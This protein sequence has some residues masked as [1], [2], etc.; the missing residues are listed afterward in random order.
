M[1]ELADN[2]R[3][4][5]YGWAILFAI[6]V[7]TSLPPLIGY[8]TAQTLIGF[9]YGITP[10]F[11][12]SAGSCLVGGVFS[13]LVVRRLVRFFAPFIQRDQTFQALSNAV[14]VKG[15]PLII[16][17]RLCPFP[18]PYSNAFFASVESVTLS[19]FFLA[20]LT[21]TPKLLLHVFIGHR[22]YLFA[23]PDAR[24]KMDPLSRW[25]N[26][27]F[28]VVGSALGFGTSWYLYRVTMRF[29]EEAERERSLAA[30]GRDGRGDGDVDL[31]LESGL[32]GQ[33]DEL[34][35]GQDDDDAEEHAVEEERRSTRHRPLAKTKEEK[36]VDVHDEE[37]DEDEGWSR[38][39][40]ADFSDFEERTPTRGPAEGA[41]VDIDETV[42]PA[43]GAAAGTGGAR[44][45]SEAWGFDDDLADDDVTPAPNA[46]P[47]KKR[48][49]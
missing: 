13:F 4:L 36:L 26:L 17:L 37:E 7:V 9:S 31:D 45:D 32:L 24:H 18:Y 2:I 19:Q 48:I 3:K 34:L 30:G 23:S 1:A 15:L 38:D 25:I 22:T 8:G 28:M 6:V 46:G 12:I 14:K 49:D 27:G 20:T 41:L 44:R 10:G 5:P 43:R 40:G 21:I 35:D 16:L 29:V 11:Y 42:D 33:V 47:V 39:D